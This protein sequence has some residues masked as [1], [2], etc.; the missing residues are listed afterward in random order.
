MPE[1]SGVE[2][3]R[4][5][6]DHAP[7]IRV[8]VLTMHED[9]GHLHT[10]LRA[11]VSG[12]VVK[13]AVHTELVEAIR[14]VHHGDAYLHPTVAKLLVRDS[15]KRPRQPRTDEEALTPREHEILKLI[16]EGYTN[17]EIAERLFLSIKTVETH[18]ERIMS[19]LDFKTRAELV[20]YALDTGLL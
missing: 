4:R 16:A 13:S 7:D 8:V 9:A 6:K 20:R 17:R 14:A 18:R 10:A 15:I 12:Y 2:A 11:G 3:T 19:K 5:I 1:L